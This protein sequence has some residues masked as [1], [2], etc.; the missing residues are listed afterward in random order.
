MDLKGGRDRPQSLVKCDGGGV[1]KR[2][3]QGVSPIKLIIVSIR[4]SLPCRY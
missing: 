2:I 1:Y 3:V 4:Y